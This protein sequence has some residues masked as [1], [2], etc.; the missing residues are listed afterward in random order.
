MIPAGADMDI[1]TWLHMASIDGI[2][3]LD[4]TSEVLKGTAQGKIAGN[5]SNWVTQDI[6]LGD[7]N[8]GINTMTQHLQA[9]EYTMGSICG[10][11]ESRMGEI[12]ERQAVRNT[13]FEMAQ[14]QKATEMQFKL[15]ENVRRICL[16]KFVEVIK[17]FHRDNPIA[18]SYFLNDMAQEFLQSCDDLAECEFDINVSNSNEDTKLMARFEQALDNGIAQGNVDMSM[19][20][21]T[22]SNSIQKIK[23][24]FRERE[25]EKAE[26]DQKLQQQAEASQKE[27]MMLQIQEKDKQREHEIAMKEA[28]LEIKKYD[29]DQR[30]YVALTTQENNT[31][32]PELIDDN[33]TD[34]VD[35]NIRQGQL[36]ETIRHNKTKEKLEAEKNSIA[37]IQKRKPSSTK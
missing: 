9:L 30:T 3:L 13:Q 20:L 16:K 17:L 36:N 37:R 21:A 2:L 8:E 6:S 35:L 29:I 32:E 19:L 7:N 4:P 23:T 5:I 15:E 18:G 27:L 22:T 10:I 34:L 1:K 25:K 31:E 24:E 28:E 12:G 11:P 26:R 33:E 14:F